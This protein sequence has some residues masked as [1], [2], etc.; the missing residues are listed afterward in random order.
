MRISLVKMYFLEL[1]SSNVFHGR[2]YAVLIALV[3]D[4]LSSFCIAD[5]EVLYHKEVC[6]EKEFY[7]PYVKLLKTRQ[8]QHEHT[9]ILKI[10]SSGYLDVSRHA[11]ILC[12]NGP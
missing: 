2:K 1:H 9:P 12:I 5:I 7:S 11:G 8:P 6:E 10:L 3:L 4:I